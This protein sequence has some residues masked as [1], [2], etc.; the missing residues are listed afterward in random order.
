MLADEARTPRLTSGLIVNEFHCGDP[1]SFWVDAPP[2]KPL[3]EIAG[4]PMIQHVYAR[5]Q[6]SRADRVLSQQT[7]GESRTS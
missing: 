1:R 7:I 2:G 5:A 3:L 4:Q 6:L